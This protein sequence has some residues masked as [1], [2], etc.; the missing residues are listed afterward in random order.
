[1]TQPTVKATKENL[2]KDFNA[3]IIDV[4]QLLK[5]V[6]SEGGD[7]ANAFRAKVEQNLKVAKERLHHIEEGTIN[8]TKAAARV[9]DEYVHEHP[10]PVIGA[11]VCLGVVIGLLLNRR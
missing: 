11:A 9:T 7:K 1:M 5:S 10:W 2:F 4:E 3:V 8:R 6:A